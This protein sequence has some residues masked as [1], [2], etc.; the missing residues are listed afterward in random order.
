MVENRKSK[1]IFLTIV[2]LFLLVLPNF[3]NAATVTV[4]KV[5]GEK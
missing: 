1:I 2:F 3:S 5:K 4:G